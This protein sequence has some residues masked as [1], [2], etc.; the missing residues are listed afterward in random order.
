MVLQNDSDRKQNDAIS[1]L[2]GNISS[3]NHDGR[4]LPPVWENYETTIYTNNFQ[5]NIYMYKRNGGY[6]QIVIMGFLTANLAADTG[7]R[8]I[9]LI[10]DGARPEVHQVFPGITKKGKTIWIHIGENGAINIENYSLNAAV[11]ERND[12]F[13]VVKVYY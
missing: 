13:Y 9:G 2:N 12:Y 3:H 8:Y 6:K 11:L 1:E 5:G 7:G 10:P 4:Y